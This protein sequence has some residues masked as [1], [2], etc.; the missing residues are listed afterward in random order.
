MLCPQFQ[1]FFVVLIQSISKQ[2]FPSIIQFGFNLIM[3]KVVTNKFLKK[4]SSD[5][6]IFLILV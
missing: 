4:G 5:N 6:D 3:K 1:Y 2:S